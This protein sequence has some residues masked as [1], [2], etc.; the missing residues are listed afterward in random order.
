MC[1]INNLHW[2]IEVEQRG[3]VVV[4]EKSTSSSR[5]AE[6][7]LRYSVL[8]LVKNLS[9]LNNKQTKHIHNIPKQYKDV[10][11]GTE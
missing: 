9:F 5:I 1:L 10:F 7:Y 8:N 6:K 3:P 2:S 4:F 11:T